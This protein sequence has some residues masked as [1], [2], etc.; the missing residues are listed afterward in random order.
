MRLRIIAA[1]LCAGTTAV[2]SPAWA[3]DASK[4]ELTAELT[5]DALVEGDIARF[6]AGVSRVRLYVRCMQRII[7]SGQA[8][9]VHRTI[10]LKAFHEGDMEAAKAALTAS[11]QSDP[12]WEVPEALDE[13]WDPFRSL[14]AD[15][16]EGSAPPTEGVVGLPDTTMF[17]DGTRG[18]DRP[19]DVPVILQKLD[20][21][22]A[23][24][25]G[26][27]LP[28]GAE[29]PAWAVPPEPKDHGAVA[30]DGGWP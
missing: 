26:S 21:N 18:Q 24:F 11:V 16:R 10:A 14:L 23:H 7:T 13:G 15:L 27:W 2:S 12:W 5:S 28:A 8:G 22:D 6:N 19:R 3:C 9:A 30:D 20:L 1:A 29:L 17:W 25:T 4:L